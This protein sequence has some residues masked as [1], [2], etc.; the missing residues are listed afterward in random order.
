MQ[1][2]CLLQSEA[3]LAP[4]TA[5]P[6]LYA[7]RPQRGRARTDVRALVFQRQGRHRRDDVQSRGED[8]LQARAQRRRE[9]AVLLAF[10]RPGLLLL[11]QGRARAR[12]PQTRRLEEHVAALGE[13]RSALRRRADHVHERLIARRDFSPRREAAALRRRHWAHWSASTG[14]RSSPTPAVECTRSSL[15]TR[16]RTPPCPRTTC[17]RRRD[18]SEGRTPFST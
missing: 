16:A 10:G 18:N 2:P 5:M 1:V 4:Q 7:Q 14:A 3:M 12:D 17:P 6:F 8:G 11:E 15:G 9:R 13:L